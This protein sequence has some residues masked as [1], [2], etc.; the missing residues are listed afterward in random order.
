MQAIVTD[1]SDRATQ[2]WRTDLIKV[3]SH[4]GIEGNEKADYLATTSADMEDPKNE[5][6]DGVDPYANL[7][8]PMYEYNTPSTTDNDTE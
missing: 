3:R 6:R 8:W 7:F 1:I 2:G 4:I 5:V